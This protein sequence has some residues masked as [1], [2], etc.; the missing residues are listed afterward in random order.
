MAACGPECQILG[1]NSMVQDPYIRIVLIK[2]LKRPRTL[3]LR[4]IEKDTGL[5][6]AWLSM[7]AQG[8]IEDP[9][10]TRIVKLDTYLSEIN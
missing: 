10:Y 3:T 7:F 1:I 6:R 8:K 9:S 2:L 5:N 4:T